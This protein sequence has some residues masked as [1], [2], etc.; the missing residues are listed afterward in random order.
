LEVADRHF[1]DNT[2]RNQD[3]IRALKAAFLLR[4]PVRGL[5]EVPVNLVGLACLGLLGLGNA[6][7]WFAGVGLE[8]VYLVSLATNWRFQ[9]WVNARASME[10][11]EEIEATREALLQQLAQADKVAL[12]RLA[13]Q[14]RRV[15]SLWRAQDDVVL[16]SNEQALRDLQWVYLKLLLARQHVKSSE[17]EANETELRASIQTLERELTDSRLSEATRESKS[18]T[19]NLLRRRAENVGRRRQTLDEIG[20]DL[21]RIEAQV[22]LVLENTALEG[23]PQAVSADLDLA[24]QLLDGSFFG[25]SAADIAALD[26]A[27][28]RPAP[29]E[30]VSE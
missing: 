8:T 23:K 7:F 11:S 6:G 19:L 10:T 13:G 20:S 5:G 28:A 30:K 25:A 26:A 16:Q 2:A 14:C 21:T 9:R 29:S 24:S 3:M 18:A 12:E 15:E 17:S 4:Y 1:F 27:Y 22:A